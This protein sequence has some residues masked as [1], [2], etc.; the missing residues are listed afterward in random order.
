[1]KTKFQSLTLLLLL[2]LLADQSVAQC[3]CGHIKWLYKMLKIKFEIKEP[4]PITYVT[5]PNSIYEIPFTFNAYCSFVKANNL[6]Y[7]YLWTTNSR[8]KSYEK[9]DYHKG[10]SI[11]FYL[12]GGKVIESSCFSDYPGIKSQ[13]ISFY[14]L[15]KEDL[16]LLST[17]S[18]D[19]LMVTNHPTG[20]S[21]GKESQVTT[22]NTVLRFSD[23]NIKRFKEWSNCLKQEL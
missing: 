12:S 8:Y 18:L 16:D 19:S 1:M 14:Q 11:K 4:Q 10:D 23:R 5:G 13:T 9:V 6:P 17:T 20:M 3:K 22:Q 7:F 2:T 15:K 21:N